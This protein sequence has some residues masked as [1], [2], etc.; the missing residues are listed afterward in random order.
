MQRAHEKL[1][2]WQDAMD[3][4][5]TIYLLTQSF[6]KHEQFTLS[7]QMRRAA[8]SIPSNIAEGASRGS[9]KEFV[10]FLQIARAS[11]SEL[12]TQL[13]IAIRLSYIE[14]NNTALQDCNTVFAK[15][16]GLIN[17]LN[18]QIV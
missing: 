17:K 7:A 16:S 6:P 5:E 2:V 13:K 11:L 1:T 10:R 12:E 9:D 18:Q 8:I 15:L 3:L 4:V 14:Q